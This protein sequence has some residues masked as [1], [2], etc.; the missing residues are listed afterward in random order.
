MEIFLTEKLFLYFQT[1]ITDYLGKYKLEETT[2]RSSSSALL[3]KTG[4]KF[5]ATLEGKAT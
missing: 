2:K 3:R 4:N 5:S 1:S